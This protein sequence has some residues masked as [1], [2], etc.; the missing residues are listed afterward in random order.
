MEYFDVDKFLKVYLKRNINIETKH[1][2]DWVGCSVRH[3]Q[4][5]GKLN[6]VPFHRIHG[7]K[8][9][10]WNETT[11]REFGKWFNRNYK[12]ETRIEVNRTKKEVKEKIKKEHKV[13]FRTIK[14]L[15]IELC[16][17]EDTYKIRIFQKWA[18]LFGVP[19]QYHFGR[20]F[21][22]ISDEIKD[23]FIELDKNKEF[24]YEVFPK[25]IK[26]ELP[27]YH[28]KDIDKLIGIAREQYQRTK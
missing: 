18:K 3:I 2:S 10:I 4:K 15:V 9:Y 1:L 25:K 24:Y 8:H 6:D 21:Y 20:K 23:I 19:F 28:N 7:I 14:D 17:K 16:G 11:I 13:N 27:N 22:I 26:T 12:K 5:F